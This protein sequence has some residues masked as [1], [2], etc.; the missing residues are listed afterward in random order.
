MKSS[1]TGHVDGGVMNKYVPTLILLNEAVP[2]PFTKP[3]NSSFCHSENL[4]K[5]FVPSP[6]APL[7]QGKQS[8]K[9]QLTCER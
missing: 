5:N 2:F 7:W 6:R 1:E 4:L 3:F 9:A 8:S